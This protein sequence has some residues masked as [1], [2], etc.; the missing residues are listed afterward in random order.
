MVRRGTQDTP[1]S[2]LILRYMHVAID[3]YVLVIS[4]RTMT[5]VGTSEMDISV[6]HCTAYC[7]LVL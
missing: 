1:G 7:I 5:D 4:Y 2:L 3:D 6:S